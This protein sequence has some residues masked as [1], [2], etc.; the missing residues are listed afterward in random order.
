MMTSSRRRSAGVCV[1]ALAVTL[2]IVVVST[3]SL[4]IASAAQVGENGGG[5]GNLSIESLRDGG[6]QLGG[7][8][9]P[10]VRMLSDTS[11]ISVR[12]YPVEPFPAQDWYHLGEQSPVR[13]DELEIRTVRYGSVDNSEL[14][15]RL[16]YWTPETREIK[17]DNSTVAT[18][19]VANISRTE[20]KTI[21]AP[22]GYGAA[23]ITLRSHFGSAEKVTMCIQRPGSPNCLDDPG[24]GARYVFDHQSADTSQGVPFETAGG[25]WEWMGLNIII[26]TLG[27]TGAIGFLVPISIRR[28]G[29]GPDMGLPF[30]GF[31]LAIGALVI[32]SSAY[33]LFSSLL[34]AAP[35]V[36]AFL[37][38]GT[39][40]IIFLEKYE[41][42]VKDVVLFRMRT[43]DSETP[44]GEMAKTATAG[45]FVKKKMVSM[46]GGEG[47]AVIPRGIRPWLARLFGG[48]TIVHGLANAGNEMDLFNSKADKLLFVD[49]D[50]DEL[51]D[52]EPERLTFRPQFKTP[53]RWRDISEDAEREWDL[54]EI[55]GMA[56]WTIGGAAAAFAV[57]GMASVAAVAGGL[58]LLVTETE[59]VNG[60]AF[61]DLAPNHAHKAYAT[62]MYLDHELDQY[63]SFEKALEALLRE[64]SKTEDF[65]E[66]LEDLD[67]E[68]VVTAAHERDTDQ[69]DPFSRDAI[70]G[71]S[72][73]GSESGQASKGGA[74]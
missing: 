41:S 9:P 17:L 31:V 36:V 4:G 6:D 70:S 54:V 39:V 51:I 63:D 11:S 24:G 8:A 19:Q 55:T 44:N 53:P 5:G 15:V 67:T 12:H 74:D 46:P 72:E 29:A 21:R 7:A 48:A 40:G 69:H 23:N 43:K 33:Y 25:L 59:A 18:R 65:E 57:T 58:T 1:L 28:T 16:A 45:E 66:Y 62:A 50:A 2:V 10:S 3:P 38:A 68:N 22:Q 30:W 61:V 32:L 35:Y 34:V 64:R 49:S 60:R 42:G 56:V 26:P 37:I 14:T 73:S 52:E 71:D 20:T 13:A 27:A 47:V